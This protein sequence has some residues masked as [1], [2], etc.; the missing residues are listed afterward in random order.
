VLFTAGERVRVRVRPAMAELVTADPTLLAD[1]E[2]RLQIRLELLPDESIG[3]SGFS[4]L[5]S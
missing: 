5:R 2:E 4:I 3:P 1:A